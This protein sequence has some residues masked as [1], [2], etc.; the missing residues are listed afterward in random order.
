MFCPVSF[1]ACLLFL[2]LGQQ[3]LM[4]S[5]VYSQEKALKQ[6]EHLISKLEDLDLDCT[7]TAVMRKQAILLLEGKKN[8]GSLEIQVY[9]NLVKLCNKLTV[10]KLLKIFSTC[11]MQCI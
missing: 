1:W 7:L 5:G 11:L 6:E 10:L 8:K 9:Y 2:G 4:P 3:R